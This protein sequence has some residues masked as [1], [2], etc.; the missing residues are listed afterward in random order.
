MWFA[1]RHDLLRITQVAR[2][3]AAG[4]V[5]VGADICQGLWTAPVAAGN[6][7]D[8]AAQ[9]M[10]QNGV[11]IEADPE[12]IGPFA[13]QH[14]QL[15]PLLWTG[16]GVPVLEDLVEGDVLTLFENQLTGGLWARR[17]ATTEPGAAG[18][19]VFQDVE[20]RLSNGQ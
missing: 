3:A 9:L 12:L 4:D 18:G 10:N 16:T 19:T 17:M 1:G 15:D 20:G 7:P 2:S 11:R 6:L 14:H 5:E 8:V 13:A